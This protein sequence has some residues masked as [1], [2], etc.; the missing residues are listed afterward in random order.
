VTGT[1]IGRRGLRGG[2]AATGLA[3]V[4][5][6]LTAAEAAA[7]SRLPA[8]VDIATAGDPDHPGPFERSADMTGGARDSRL[9]G[10]SGLVPQRPAGRLGNAIALRAPVHRIAQTRASV[11]PPLTGAR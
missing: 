2:L 8:T 4:G 3:A 5:A 9:V 1:V 11:V 7:Q 6:P 10:G